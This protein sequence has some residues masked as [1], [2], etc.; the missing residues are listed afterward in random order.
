M[1]EHR[2]LLP[3]VE[4]QGAM[5]SVRVERGVEDEGLL[6]QLHQM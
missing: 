3:S 1:T 2:E 6:P 5:V 4:A